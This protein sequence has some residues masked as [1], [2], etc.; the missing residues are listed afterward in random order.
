[1]I[2]ESNLRQEGFLDAKFVRLMWDEHLAKKRNWQ[3]QL[4][5]VLMFQSWLVNH[6]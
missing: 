5:S 6:E 4:W 1:L 3:G 2:E